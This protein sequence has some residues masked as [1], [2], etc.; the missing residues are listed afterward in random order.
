[1]RYDG[2]ASLAWSSRLRGEHFCYAMHEVPKPTRPDPL[3]SRQ[4]VRERV[5]RQP[6]DNSKA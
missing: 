6:T 1:V 2:A 4:G 5:P 3:L